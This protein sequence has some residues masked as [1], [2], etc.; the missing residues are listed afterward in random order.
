MEFEISQEARLVQDQVERFLNEKIVPNERVYA[1][2]AADISDG[3]DPQIMKTLRAEAK[4]LGLWNLFLPD[5]EWGA[6]LSN[7]DY[8]ACCAEHHGSFSQSPRGYSIV[9]RR[10]PG[11]CRDSCRVRVTAAQKERPG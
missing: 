7:H 4:A 9:R 1:E 6:G 3:Q 10:I 2:Q 11:T 8:S 5:K